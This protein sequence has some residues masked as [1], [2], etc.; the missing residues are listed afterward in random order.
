MCTVVPWE[1]WV[2]WMELRFWGGGGGSVFDLWVWMWVHVDFHGR[3][4]GD[5]F[6]IVC[7]TSLDETVGPSPPCRVVN[8]C[9]LESSSKMTMERGDESTGNFGG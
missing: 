7:I 9:H 1:F 6:V 4:L 8:N 5:V 2:E 3:I